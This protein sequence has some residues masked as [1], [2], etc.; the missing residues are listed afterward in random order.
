MKKKGLAVIYDPHNL[1]QF[2]WYYC[3]KGKEKEWDALCLPNG[4]KG[5]YMHTYCEAAGIFQ[6]IYRDDVDFL[7][8]PLRKKM[9]IFLKMFIY[10]VAGRRISYC[11]KF[12]NQYVREK[13]YDEIVVLCDYGVVSGACCALGKEKEVVILEDGIGDYGER[14]RFIPLSKIWSFF[15]WQGF[16]LAAMGYC[17]KGLF[18]TNTSRYCIKY[19]SHPDQMIYKKFKEI[20][21]LY[22]DKGTDEAL[23]NRI[24]ER[25]YP[26][27]RNYDFQ[28][29]EVVIMTRPLEDYVA[30]VDRY[31]QRFEA[32]VHKNYNDVLL[33]KHPREEGQYNFGTNVRTVE[34]D[35]SIPAEAIF[36]YVKGKD[37]LII[38]VSSV[39][40]Y[41]NT[42]RMRC[43]AVSFDGLYEECIKSGSTFRPGNKNEQIDFY[44]KFV[45]NNYRIVH[46]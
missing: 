9:Q 23:F 1:Y 8:L 6:N 46:L 34:I 22:D 4:Y 42:Y 43:I 15:Y 40:L 16:F 3:N 33:K 20:R 28:N 18:R 12:I 38:E 19:S 29:A 39:I 26:S 31:K 41:A 11:R 32:Y 21:L 24:V 37:F 36:P 14:P 30:N 10:F 45:N 5:E 13:D 25:I 35:N 44:E 2:V 7:V 27:L 17:G